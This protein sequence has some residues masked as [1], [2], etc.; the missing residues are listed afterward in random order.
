VIGD[1]GVAV[2]DTQ[3]NLPLARRVI[4]SVRE[5]TD[6]PIL[7]A[8]N[9]H[10]HWDHTNGNRVFREAG[11]ELIARQMTNDFMVQRSPR[12]KAF[13]SGRGLPLGED[14]VLAERT[15]TGELELDL[16]GQPMRLTYLGSAE[17]E[18]ATA[19]HLPA[20]GC[21]IAG[22]TVMTGSFPI[23]GQP[24]WNEGLM[25]QYDW[26]KALDKVRALKP[27]HV[28]PGHGPLAHD[29]EID[30]LERISRFFLEEV[31]KRAKAG[32]T[33]DQILAD[34]EP[35][36]PEW[37]VKL[38]V[39]WGCPRYAILRVYRGCIE[40]AVPGF[41]HFKP[42][43]VPAA[44]PAAV[45]AKTAGLDELQKYLDAAAQTTEGGDLGT[46]LGIYREGARRFPGDP[47]AYVALADAL[48]AGARIIASVLEKGDF[49]V[50]AHE[51]IEK[52]L[53]IDPRFGPAWLF[54]GQFQIMSSYRNGDDPAC[55]VKHVEKAMECGLDRHG[56]A[57]SLFFLGMARR[58]E[59]D[60]PGARDFFRKALAIEPDYPQAA[61]ALA[62]GA[63]ATGGGR[64][65]GIGG[66]EPGVRG[67]TGR[68]R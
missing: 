20:E 11:A 3:V 52:A 29:A 53:E 30:T 49:F 54:R 6:K 15:F 21:L 39:V 37:I 56:K 26:M 12:Q 1:K 46:G 67:D 58:T 45:A 23:F 42:S 40:D 61:M 31:T 27:A 16:G 60:E 17:S 64:P 25:E 68:P 24:V 43:A 65:E 48:I 50:E 36:L 33:L 18:D 35:K 13:L 34:L 63:T 62:A 5:I 4:K 38:P 57:Q 41:Q 7:Y 47:R 44:D 51:A 32:M 59:A 14:P 2:L 9:T 55:G 22:D 19:V 8:I 10:Y 66:P 28:L